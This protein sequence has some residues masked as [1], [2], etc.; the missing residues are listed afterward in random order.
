MIRPI[1][2][3]TQGFTLIGKWQ[4]SRMDGRRLKCLR[5]LTHLSRVGVA[6]R[7]I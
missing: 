4:R 7:T 1:L 3:G 6:E 5:S 2:R